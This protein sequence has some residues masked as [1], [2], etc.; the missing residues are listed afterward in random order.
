MKP[1]AW[2][3]IPALI[4]AA[5]RR[6]LRWPSGLALLHDRK[7]A[8]SLEFAM[9]A[10]VFVFWLVSLITGG[11]TILAQATIDAATQVAGRQ[12]QIGAIRG[13]SADAVRSIVCAR[14]QGLAPQCSGIQ[15]YATS[16]ISFSSLAL[17]KVTGTTL[18]SSNFAPGGSQAYVLLQI[19]YNSPF[20]LPL[21]GTS[22]LTLV[23]TLAFKNEP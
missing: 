3:T 9:V 19:A 22:N 8:T 12:I 10:L 15:V 5:A 17:A 20:A 16:G 21:A 23:S 14:L 11:L 2:Q 13:S 7:A 1:L 18:S 4:L 6:L